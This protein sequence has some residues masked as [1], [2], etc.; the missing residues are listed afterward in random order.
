VPIILIHRFCQVSINND[1][2]PG[3]AHGGFLALVINKAQRDQSAIFVLQYV[4]DRPR[5]LVQKVLRLIGDA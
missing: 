4:Y 1:P 3:L 5:E 2:I